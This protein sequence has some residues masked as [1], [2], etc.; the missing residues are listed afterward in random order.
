MKIVNDLEI[1]ISKKNKKMQS[2]LSITILALSEKVTNIFFY[3]P[4]EAIMPKQTKL[5]L[6][7]DVART[8]SFQKRA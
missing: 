2:K 7:S 3:N 1:K 6:S 5:L 4:R 8:C